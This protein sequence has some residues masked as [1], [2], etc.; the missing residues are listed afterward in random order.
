V[1]AAATRDLA[2]T[3]RARR[4]DT[5]TIEQV[6]GVFVHGTEIGRAL[7]DAG[8]VESPRGLTLRRLTA[9]DA[10]REGARA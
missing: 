10:V 7:R 1:I 9:G 6:N 8:F 3:A 4:L 2:A 5:L